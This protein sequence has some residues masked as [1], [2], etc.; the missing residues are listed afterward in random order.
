M[1]KKTTPQERKKFIEEQRAQ[2]QG[3]GARAV[4]PRDRSF[5][6]S[7]GNIVRPTRDNPYPNVKGYTGRS[8]G[9]KNPYDPSKTTETPR[10]AESYRGPRDLAD[11]LSGTMSIIGILGGIFFLSNNIT[12]NV[13]GNMTNS[14]SNI[15]GVTFLLVGLVAGFFWLKSRN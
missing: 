6:D 13:I 3:Y 15:I 5:I 11:G 9:R 10:Q 12:G 8:V 2:P 4:Y 1:T 14:T 7:S